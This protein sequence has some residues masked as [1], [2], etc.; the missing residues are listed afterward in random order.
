MYKFDIKDNIFKVTKKYT[1]LHHICQCQF[2]R[3]KKMMTYPF[4]DEQG[5]AS[6]KR[7][8]SHSGVRGT[9]YSREWLLRVTLQI[10]SS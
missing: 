2:R 6:E 7:S 10:F 4:K 8:L 5:K 1:I 3:S 9:D